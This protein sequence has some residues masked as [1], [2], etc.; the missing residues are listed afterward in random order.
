MALEKQLDEVMGCLAQAITSTIAMNAES[1]VKER[2]AK[3]VSALEKLKK[4]GEDLKAVGKGE[5]YFALQDAVIA[6]A[7]GLRGGA[8]GPYVHLP[9]LPPCIV[10]GP[11]IISFSYQS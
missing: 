5:A 11:L 7:R 2:D 10:V 9:F 1:L 3:L 6:L 8:K 4:F